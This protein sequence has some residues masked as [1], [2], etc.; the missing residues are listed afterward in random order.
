MSDLLR[1]YLGEEINREA[2]VARL[3]ELLDLE[4]A[5]PVRP[6]ETHNERRST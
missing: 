3:D 1:I 5:V 6:R 2:A 4:A